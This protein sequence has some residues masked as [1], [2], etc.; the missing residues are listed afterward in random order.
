M[1][2][3]KLPSDSVGS[4]MCR[5]MSST[6]SMPA[7]L[8]PIDSMPKAGSQPS[9]TENRMMAISDSQNS[10]VAYSS[11]APDTSTLSSQR[12][13]FSERVWAASTPTATPRTRENKK[14]VEHKKKGGWQA[15]EDQ[16]QH[17]QPVAVR[18]SEVHLC[19]AP[20]VVAQLH[21]QRPVQAELLAQLL[22]EDFIARPG[23]ARQHGGRIAGRHAYQEEVQDHDTEHH[24]QGLGESGNKK[25]RETHRPSMHVAKGTAGVGAATPVCDGHQSDCATPGGIGNRRGM[26]APGCSFFVDINLVER[27]V[28]ADGGGHQVLHVGAGER[29]ELQLHQVDV[30][31]LLRQQLLQLAVDPLALGRI[32]RGAAALPERIGLR[33]AV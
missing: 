33:V 11:M 16:I 24:H 6:R 2:M 30:G 29:G 22:H 1:A 9:T 28:Q 3:K 27:L 15:V 31:D 5:P 20:K 4:T 8:A 13:R 12:R 18:I 19:N 21:G 7:R 26:A 14:G 25:G 10:G 17:R 32:E 23:L